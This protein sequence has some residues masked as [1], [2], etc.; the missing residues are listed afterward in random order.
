MVQQYT[1]LNVI[2]END[3]E[4]GRIYAW[5]I[6]HKEI[7][8]IPIPIPIFGGRPTNGWSHRTS[9]DSRSIVSQ[10]SAEFCL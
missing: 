7:I 3:I 2:L 5:R 4:E 9:V 1:P 8:P 10:G 6:G